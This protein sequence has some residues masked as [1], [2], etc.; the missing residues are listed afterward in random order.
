MK[1]N[2]IGN[3]LLKIFACVFTIVSLYLL[4]I[5]ITS[6][7]GRLFPM[8]KLIVVLGA[9][10][11][12]AIL[13]ILKHI[14]DRLDDKKLIKISILFGI[15]LLILQVIFVIYC[16]VKP[17]WDFGV[18]FYDAHRIANSVFELP[19]Y[20]YNF[21][22]NNIGALLMYTALFKCISLF[23][24]NEI[25][26]L[27]VGSIFNIIMIDGAL[28]LTYILVK[29]VFNLKMATLFSFLCIFIIPLF[30]YSPILYTDTTT[31]IFP[32]AILL[33]LYNYN[34]SK[35]YDE[36]WNLIGIGVF[37]ALGVILKT[38]II[39]VVVAI[40]IYILCTNKIIKGLVSNL[41]ILI[42]FL[43]IFSG[44]KAIAS[45]VMPIKYSEAGLPMTHW[46]MMGLKGDGGYN[47]EDV[48]FTSSFKD[49][50]KAKKANIEEIE[51]R[52]RD[53]G[54]KGYLEFLDKK[55]KFTW[56]DGTYY[57]INKL[58]RQPLEDN[59]V[60]EYVIGEKNNIIIYIAQMSNLALIALI[61]ISSIA[62]FKYRDKHKIVQCVQIAIFGV[63]LFLVIWE[64]RSRY[65]VCIL[66]MMMFAAIG[67]LYSLVGGEDREIYK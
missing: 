18:I 67:G 59:K 32:V 4:F 43:V 20:Y 17:S 66:P 13:L 7:Y 19:E 28:M 1:L 64:A 10:I 53:Y 41:I 22:P 25:V 21:Y 44:Y 56:N 42:S 6:N 12:L 14:F 38:N 48:D 61:F 39:I 45:Y 23:T 57:S 63:F 60:E 2:S 40:I 36:I 29:K 46:I 54:F 11:I 51:N 55:I 3:I 5:N 50:E 33:F 26:Y 49:K 58:C 52:L 47:K 16:R 35:S 27:I 15:I 9:I 24:T 62:A 37:G 65:L 30:A 34:E 31:M 8:N